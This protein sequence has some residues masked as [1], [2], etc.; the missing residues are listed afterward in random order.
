MKKVIMVGLFLLICMNTAY[1]EDDNAANFETGLSAINVS[2]PYSNS[3][4]VGGKY[5]LDRKGAVEGTVSFNFQ[6]EKENEQED[7]LAFDV[8]GAYLQ[9]I[10]IK[11][12]A[13]YLKYGG[14]ISYAMGDHYEAKDEDEFGL[15]AILGFGVEYF[16][17]SQFSIAAEA[18]MEFQVAPCVRFHTI[19]PAIK[20][21]FYFDYFSAR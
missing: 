13:P 3:A 9:Y 14:K 4:A 7:G 18:L 17:T 2:V 6:H 15:A 20:A 10:D 21:S 16:V 12:I 8:S 19:T 11:R 1:A 5:F